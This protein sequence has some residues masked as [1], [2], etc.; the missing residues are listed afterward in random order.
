[1]ANLLMKYRVRDL[2]VCR[3]VRAE[4][5]MHI[6]VQPE[7]VFAEIYRVLK[8]GGSCIMTFSNRLFYDKACLEPFLHA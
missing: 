5:C 6:V 8:P 1:M 4:A 2:G 7:K 3:G